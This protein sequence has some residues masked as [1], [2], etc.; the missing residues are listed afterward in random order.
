M[1]RK[2]YPLAL[3][4]VLAGLV[5]FTAAMEQPGRA[6]SGKEAMAALDAPAEQFNVRAFGAKG[7]GRTDDT[8][9]IQEA[10]DAAASADGGGEVY[11]PAGTYRISP[12]TPGA[13]SALVVER[14]GVTVRGD[15]PEETVLSFFVHG[16]KDPAEHWMQGGEVK[17][18]FG[19][20]LLPPGSRLLNGF[21]LRGVRLTGNYPADGT[22]TY[23]DPR[24]GKGWDV[25][26]KALALGPDRNIDNVEVDNCHFDH[27]AGEVIYAGGSGNGRLAVTNTKIWATNASGIS[28]SADLLCE[29][30]EIWDTGHG[31]VESIHLVT[32]GTVQNGIY[33]DST[34]EPRRTFTKGG[35][36]G[37]NI[38]N[39]PGSKMRVEG[40][41]IRN[42]KEIGIFLT[43]AAHDVII[44]DNVLENCGLEGSFKYG[45]FAVAPGQ[46][47]G[48]APGL[49]DIIFRGNTIRH[50]AKPQ[51]GF[52]VASGAFGKVAV[53]GFVVADNTVEIAADSGGIRRFIYDALTHPES[54]RAGF[55]VRGNEVSG[56]LE[57]IA[58]DS[59]KGSRHAPR[60][61]WQENRF[62]AVNHANGD[63][64][65]YAYH[66]DQVKDITPMGPT[67]VVTDTGG[68]RHPFTIRKDEL[69]PEGFV[70]RLRG[71]FHQSA[72]SVLLE[73]DGDWNTFAQEVLIGN[74][75]TAVLRKT[76][77]GFELVAME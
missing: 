60:P 33:R 42:V 65:F 8:E 3:G 31:G 74:G 37:L 39:A 48:V 12:Q 51:A 52:A 47:Y 59:G 64:L 16:G 21:A 13:G 29:N 19:I 61:L 54:T 32:D 63:N 30:V 40:C 38:M 43:V 77:G 11:L 55:V 36:Y 76:A 50:T 25:S 67:A 44:E 10:I 71:Q 62:P 23:T 9:A 28:A 22:S 70:L 18:G 26:H 4:V 69:Y 72:D 17:R 35:R 34:F 7:D 56:K 20:R 27:W 6:M 1:I 66:K 15:G 45:Y 5:S 58:E 2:R 57:A 24:T 14:G 46:N 68:S 41:T 53:D 73:P 49:T 75:D